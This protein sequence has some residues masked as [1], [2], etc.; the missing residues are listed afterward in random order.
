MMRRAVRAG[1]RVVSVVAFLAVLPGCTGADRG[2]GDGE[3]PATD[4]ARSGDGAT[5]GSGDGATS[6]S[7][8]G[9]PRLTPAT[10][11]DQPV[12]A[13][14]REGD[15]AVYVVE[16]VGRIVRLVGPAWAP[17]PGPPALD[18]SDLVSAGGERGLLGLAFSLD[19]TTAF[20]NYTGRDGDTVVASLAVG[21]DG[22]LDRATLRTLLTVAQPYR[23]HN[24]GDLVVGSDGALYVPTG[25]GGSGG[26]PERLALDPRSPLGK[27][28][29]VDPATGAVREIARGLRNPWR[30]DLYDGDL[31]LADVGQ[32]EWEEVSVLRDLVGSAA[33]VGAGEAPQSFGWSAWEGPA[34]YHDDEPADGHVAPVH[35]YRHGDDGCSISGGAVAPATLVS[36]DAPEDGTGA[37]SRLAGRF[38]F[39]DYC[40]GRIWSLDPARPEAGARLELDGVDELVAIVRAGGALWVLSLGG[41][42]ARL[43]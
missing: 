11:L 14:S 34:R 38:V 3:R 7:G 5:S 12:D 24:A 13:A 9:V 10:T 22:R 35:A 40:S 4:A 27:V 29:R 20:V 8:N 37:P 2:S 41:A 33:R 30:V 6:G 28:L 32:D 43:A 1:L 16:R 19:G 15:A 25:D 26:D 36:G 17:E 18:V 21:A 31:W 42:V 39:G 23:N